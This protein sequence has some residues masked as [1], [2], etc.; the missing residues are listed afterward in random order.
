MEKKRVK[1]VNDARG[2][3]KDQETKVEVEEKM[4]KKRREGSEAEEKKKNVI[5]ETVK[6]L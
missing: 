1:K 3:T 2:K 6:G 5:S 4:G